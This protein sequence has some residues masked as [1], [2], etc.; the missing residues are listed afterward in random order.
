MKRARRT[1]KSP[2]SQAEL[3][4]AIRKRLD[5]NLFLE[6]NLFFRSSGDAHLIV[7]I[8][9]DR[10]LA[11]RLPSFAA[12]KWILPAVIGT[13][14]LILVPTAVLALVSAWL[15]G[16]PIVRFAAAAERIAIDEA[17]DEPFQAEGTAELR[18]LA[19][20]LNVMRNRV[21]ELMEARTSMLTSISHD[22]RTPLTRLR[23]RAERCQDDDLRQKMLKD[24]EMLSGMID[25][26]LAYLDGTL[27]TTKKVELSSLLQTV[28]SDYLDVGVQ[29]QFKGPRRLIYDCKPR[30]IS[31][32]VSNLIDNASRHA[33]HVAVL[34][35]QAPDGAVIIS[36]ADDGPGISEEL[37][38]KVLEPFFKADKART[39]TSGA[40]FG[41]GLAIARGIVTKGHGGTFELRDRNPHGLAIIMRL[42]PPTLR[43]QRP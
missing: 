7:A 27:E 31:R 28:T 39:A 30:S 37:K 5:P 3:P 19:G 34:L 43:E 42:P 25:E 36:V 20:S 24:I 10:G 23:M 18:S 17:L 40:G 2:L 4:A 15:I 21:R 13:L 22:L 32:A 38:S 35:T 41:L 16:R 14:V 12:A 6:P 9:A 1:E 11:F 29:V 26:S 33:S 8:S